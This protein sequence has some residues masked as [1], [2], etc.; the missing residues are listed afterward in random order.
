V[1]GVSLGFLAGAAA[2]ALVRS[3]F[4]LAVTECMTA[5]V[6]VRLTGAAMRL[7]RSRLSCTL[8]IMRPQ[9]AAGKC[10]LLVHPG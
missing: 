1:R 4:L 5:F 3:V 8:P 9:L 6:Q 2:A 7:R 10:P